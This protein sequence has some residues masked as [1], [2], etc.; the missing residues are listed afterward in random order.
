MTADNELTQAL[1]KIASEAG[2]DRSAVAIAWILA[3]PSKILPVM[4]TNNLSR[5]ANLSD[6]MKVKMDRVT[7]YQ[8]YTLALGREVA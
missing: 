2:T 7:W 8:I 1:D 3:H 4:G 6:A 5:I